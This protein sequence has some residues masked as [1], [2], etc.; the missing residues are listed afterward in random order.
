MTEAVEAVD[1]KVGS[2]NVTKSTTKLFA[3]ELTVHC[4][5]RGSNPAAEIALYLDN[6]QLKVNH[7][8]T[9][10]M[11]EASQAARAPRYRYVGM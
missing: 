7:V 9:Q 6:Q 2:N 8:D 3:T 11:Q 10:V 5:A 4:I 1:M